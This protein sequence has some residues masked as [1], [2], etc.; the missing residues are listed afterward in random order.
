[1]RVTSV[2]T[3]YSAAASSAVPQ[4]AP[5][6]GFHVAHTSRG[7]QRQHKGTNHFAPQHQT[8]HVGPTSACTLCILHVQ[9]HTYKERGRDNTLCSDNRPVFLEIF[10]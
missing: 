4:S 1:M 3:V 9:R 7:R 10:T 5:T 2:D 8:S 6:S